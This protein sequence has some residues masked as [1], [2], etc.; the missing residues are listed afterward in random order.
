MLFK[1]TFKQPAPVESVV[2]CFV[3][4]TIISAIAGAF[5][6]PYTLNSWLIFLGKPPSVT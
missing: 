5:L 1:V 6:W 4:L 3:L 2:G